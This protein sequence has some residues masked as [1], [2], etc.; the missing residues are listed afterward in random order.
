MLESGSR[1]QGELNYYDYGVVSIKLELPFQADWPQLIDLSSRWMATPELESRALETV[2]RC[3]AGAR[4]ALVKPHENW[5][6]EDYYIIHLQET[7]PGLNGSGID[8]GTR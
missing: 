4:A 8:C 5:L 3:L 1:L 7:K 6:S 2:Q